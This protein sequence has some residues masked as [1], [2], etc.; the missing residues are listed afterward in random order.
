MWLLRSFGTAHSICTYV[1][2]FLKH[3]QDILSYVPTSLTNCF[4]EYEQRTLY[5]AL[6][7]TLAMLLRL[8]NC[9]FTIIYYYIQGSNTAAFYDDCVIDVTLLRPRNDLLC[10]G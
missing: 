7:V 4:A 1:I 2:N 5:G 8:I 6:V 9:C 10:I 3:V